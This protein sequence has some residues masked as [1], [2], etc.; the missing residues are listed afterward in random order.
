MKKLLFILSLLLIT[1]NNFLLFPVSV[2]TQIYCDNNGNQYN[3]N[4]IDEE[5]NSYIEDSI[6]ETQ[7][8]SLLTL[9]LKTLYDK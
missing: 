3:Y 2:K 7:Q 4:P 6:Y 9:S 5:R 1:T 8:D